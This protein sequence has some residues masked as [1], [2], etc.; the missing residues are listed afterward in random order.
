MLDETIR[1]KKFL[2]FSIKDI[3]ISNFMFVDDVIIIIRGSERSCQNLQKSFG[4]YF[5]TSNL[6]INRVK[7]LINFSRHYDLSIKHKIYNFLNMEE[8]SWPMTYLGT[9]IY[10]TV[11]YLKDSN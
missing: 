5:K 1:S 9:Y 2:S 8:G 11:K 6:N 7:F 3:K 10:L 4:Y